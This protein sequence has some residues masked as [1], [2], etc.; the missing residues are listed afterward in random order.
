MALRGLN[1]RHALESL[2]AAS[3]SG[4]AIRTDVDL[5][6]RMQPEHELGDDAE[7]AAA[8]T[9]RP[10][11][12]ADRRPAEAVTTEPSA[13]TT[14]GLDEVVASEPAGAHQVA[15]AAGERQPGDPRVH[16]RPAR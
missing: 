15:D 3:A 7:V 8:A 6:K 1:R 14:V 9:E 5:A 11:E 16:E 13:V 12:L 4:T 2:R 10:Q